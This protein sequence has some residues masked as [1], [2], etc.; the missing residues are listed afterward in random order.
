LERTLKITRLA[1]VLHIYVLHN[2]SF[3]SDVA[4]NR[5]GGDWYEQNMFLGTLFLP[6]SSPDV[7]S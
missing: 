3:I 6:P 5:V 2:C 4:M 7:L 1:G